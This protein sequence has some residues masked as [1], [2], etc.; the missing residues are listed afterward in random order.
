MERQLSSDVVS[1]EVQKPV[2]VRPR[3]MTQVRNRVSTLS[4]AIE[5]ETKAIKQLYRV[6]RRLAYVAVVT[7]L[8]AAISCVVVVATRTTSVSD[9]GTFVDKAGN[10]LQM[11]EK[12]EETSILDVHYASLRDLHDFKDAAFGVPFRRG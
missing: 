8:A 9:D 12:E 6:S 4:H 7:V 1:L 11:I 10:T 5:D 3:G 2:Q